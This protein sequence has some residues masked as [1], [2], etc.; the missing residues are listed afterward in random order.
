M[1]KV[2]KFPRVM[3][4]VTAA[5]PDRVVVAPALRV[6][7]VVKVLPLA[8]FRIPKVPDPTV[9]VVAVIDSLAFKVA[10]LPIVNEVIA[11]DPPMMPLVVALVPFAT[12]N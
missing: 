5:D 6:R 10:E 4:P 8:K 12:I 2:D 1:F 7:V 3:V 9:V 11:V